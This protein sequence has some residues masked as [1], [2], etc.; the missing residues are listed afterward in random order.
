MNIILLGPQGSGKGTQ[1][2]LLAEKHDLLHLAT[3]DLLRETAK[4]DEIIKKQLAS[5]KLFS[6]KQMITLVEKKIADE[7]RGIIF[8]GF[9]RTLAQAESLDEITTINVVIELKLND[10][11]AIKRISGRRECSQCHAVFGWEIKPRKEGSCNRC[12][13]KLVQRE[14]DKPE[15]VK[16]RLA[17]YHDETEPLLEYYRPRNIVYTVD[18]SRSIDVIF[19][20]LCEI[21]ERAGG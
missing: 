7:P 17:Q 11:E 12:G 21:I 18:A 14:D 6:D 20:E 5:G 9:P 8:D 19:K 3:G 2:Q 16:K 1:A 13:G 10:A 15:A 4:R